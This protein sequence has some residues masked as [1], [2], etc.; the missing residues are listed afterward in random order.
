[1]I[2]LR[3]QRRQCKKGTKFL[4]SKRKKF[5]EDLEAREQAFF[6]QAEKQR[7]ISNEQK[8]AA[9]IA[10]LRRDGSRQVTSV[11]FNI[12]DACLSGQFKYSGTSQLRHHLGL[13]EYIS[14][15]RDVVSRFSRW[16]TNQRVTTFVE[17]NPQSNS[18][19]SQSHT[20][21]TTLSCTT[22]NMLTI[23]PCLTTA[24]P[25]CQAVSLRVVSGRVKK[26]KVTNLI[27]ILTLRP[28]LDYHYFLAIRSRL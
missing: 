28:S 2:N 20:Q 6:E 3:R 11:V 16:W 5:K 23:Y 13:K 22:H 17:L 14:L 25:S 21:L 1:M 4:D 26:S 27:S 12:N 19:H 24:L 9:E 15:N 18:L 7:E 10:R 8:L